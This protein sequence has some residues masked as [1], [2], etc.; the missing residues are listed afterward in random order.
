MQVNVEA[1]DEPET[2]WWFRLISWRLVRISAPSRSRESSASAYRT[3]SRR[4]AGAFQLPLEQAVTGVGKSNGPLNAREFYGRHQSRSIPR[5]MALQSLF[6]SVVRTKS[7]VVTGVVVRHVEVN[8]VDH[9]PLH[10]LDCPRPA[11]HA[12]AERSRTKGR[13]LQLFDAPSD[14]T[15]RTAWQTRAP[16]NRA[17]SKPS[18]SGIR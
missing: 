2:E 5:A 16:G 11:G 8:D 10:G 14:L 6:Q 15:A 1:S 12:A 3:E 13:R 7:N 18:P 9:V 4:V 17:N